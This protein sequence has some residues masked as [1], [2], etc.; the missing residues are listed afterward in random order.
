[1]SQILSKALGIDQVNNTE[2]ELSI[3]NLQPS[4]EIR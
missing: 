4:W 2:M 3:Q 1:M